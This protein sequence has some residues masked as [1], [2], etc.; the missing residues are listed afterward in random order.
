MPSLAWLGS[1]WSRSRVVWTR[2]ARPRLVP[3]LEARFMTSFG[4]HGSEQAFNLNSASGKLPT[5]AQTL[6]QV[7]EL[8]LL[9]PLVGPPIQNR[10]SG[11][12]FRGP[13]KRI[14]SSRVESNF[15]PNS[16][17]LKHRQIHNTSQTKHVVIETQ[18]QTLNRNLNAHTKSFKN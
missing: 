17:R 16:S 3:P 11:C 7:C 1:V 12:N 8:S 5:K 15:V 9:R 6:Q 10:A 14:Q 13:N 4:A 2:I 18:T